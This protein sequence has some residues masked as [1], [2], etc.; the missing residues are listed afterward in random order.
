MSESRAE[1]SKRHE[2]EFRADQAAWIE[3]LAH[4]RRNCSHRY[5]N[6]DWSIGL[7]HNFPDGLPRGICLKCSTVMHPVR[8]ECVR[9]NQMALLPMHSL[10]HVVIALEN[11]DAA[12]ALL[13]DI[14]L[15]AVDCL[16]NNREWS[17]LADLDV[18]YTR[19]R[20]RISEQLNADIEASK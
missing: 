6:K 1:Q 7:Q 20:A 13:R 16:T 9:S 5:A 4:V 14:M 15:A 18:I 2:K 19:A 11:Q 3:P 17:A 12:S 8:F 10:Y